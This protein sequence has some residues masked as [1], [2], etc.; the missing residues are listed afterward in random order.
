MI[1]PRSTESGN[2]LVWKALSPSYLNVGVKTFIAIEYW[3]NKL[4]NARNKQNLTTTFS[5]LKRCYE[6]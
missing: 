1:I 5:Q 6:K 4:A 3:E 2:L